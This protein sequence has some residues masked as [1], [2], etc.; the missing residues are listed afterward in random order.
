MSQSKILDKTPNEVYIKRYK[1]FIR[2][3]KISKMLKSAQII[4]HQK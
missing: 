3:Y 1:N 4:I 2:L